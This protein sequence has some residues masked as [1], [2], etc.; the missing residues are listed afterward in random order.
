MTRVGSAK[1]S[2]AKALPPKVK[3]EIIATLLKSGEKKLADEVATWASFKDAVPGNLADN[4]KTAGEDEQKRSV[5]YL[6]RAGILPES[7]KAKD[8]PSLAISERREIIA[9]LL[10][11]GR[12]DLAQRVAVNR[13][14]GTVS[15]GSAQKNL[16]TELTKVIRSKASFISKMDLG[17]RP[18]AVH[19]YGALMNVVWDLVAKN[20][21]YKEMK[22]WRDSRYAT[23]IKQALKN[24]APE[25]LP[26]F[27]EHKIDKQARIKWA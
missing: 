23:I 25:V 27:D 3:Q 10:K 12:K 21:K 4:T 2:G 7:E 9:T 20:E 18:N 1:Q 15:L 5:D 22:N 11:A 16:V 24:A 14:P 19:L 8:Y 26:F 17:S 6:K 13:L